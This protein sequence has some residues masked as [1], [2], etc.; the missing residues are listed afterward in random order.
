MIW[1]E[2]VTGENCLGFRNKFKQNGKP[3]TLLLLL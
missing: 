1:I 3:Y 2:W